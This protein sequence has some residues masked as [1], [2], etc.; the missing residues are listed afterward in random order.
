MFSHPKTSLARAFIR[1]TLH[2]DIPQDYQQRM[3]T[4]VCTWPHSHIAIGIYRSS[5]WM[6]RCC[7]KPVPLQHQQ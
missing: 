4:D 6:R 2:L 1:S 7:R 5:R 3:Y